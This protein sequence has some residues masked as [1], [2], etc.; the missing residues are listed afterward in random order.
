VVFDKTPF[1]GEKG[2]QVGD[3]G[4]IVCGA[5]KFTVADAQYDGEFIVHLGTL[6]AGELTVGATATATVDAARRAAIS[7]AHTATH[8]LHAA[9]RARLGGH[10]EQQ[11]SKVDADVLRFDFTN[12]QAV[13]RET[14]VAVERDV[15]AAILAAAPVSCVETP[16]EE[17]RKLGA[18][19]LFGE[20]YP[21]IVRVV[22]MGSSM[23]FCG[24]THLQ[25]T[26]QVGFCKIVG[27]ESV[28]AG[29]RRIIAFTGM[30][31]LAKIQAA[32]EIETTLAAAL[33]VP[34]GEIV[35]RVEGLLDQT[36]KLRKEL[37]AATKKAT[38]SV[39]ELIAKAEDVA[40]TKFV[41]FVGEGAD[42][43]ALREAIDQIRRKTEN[44]AIMM[45]SVDTKAGKVTLL[46]AATRNL[47]ERKFSAVDWIKAVAKHVQGGGGGR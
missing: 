37:D 38:V 1:Y 4:E 6:A 36:K 13:D 39:D 14:L 10:A 23:E 32:D 43:G 34:A 3:S 40:G 16:I 7:R 24:G 28:G 9:L 18:M 2:G 26:A 25:N 21:D 11:G 29:T 35:G 22:T 27:E 12:H 5:A 8:L 44:A 19:M 46:A 47:V 31:A 42:P 15:N 45:A 41:T 17:A 30:E 20:K 33:R